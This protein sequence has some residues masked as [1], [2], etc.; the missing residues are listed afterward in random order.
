MHRTNGR[1]KPAVAGRVL[2]YGSELYILEAVLTTGW[3]PL[4]LDEPAEHL[5]DLQFRLR[6][7]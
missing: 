4:L 2:R 6:G 1:I 7:T 3:D 5:W